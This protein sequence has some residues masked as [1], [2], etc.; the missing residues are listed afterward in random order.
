MSSGTLTYNLLAL[1][2]IS[3]T[4]PNAQLIPGDQFSIV[5]TVGG[6]TLTD[7]T[8]TG[9]MV[10]SGGPI[11]TANINYSTSVLTITTGAFGAT[12]AT[13][14]LAYYPVLP[15]MG[16]FQRQNPG[17]NT[18]QQIT[19][20]QKYAYEYFSNHFQEL[21]STL[22]TE[23]HGSDTDFFWTCSYGENGQNANLFW[24]TNNV[25]GLHSYEFPYC[26]L[27]NQW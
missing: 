9:V 17:V 13:V 2:G 6:N 1:L 5:I 3:A 25:S 15:T 21:P 8:G 7:S 23:W 14:R 20:D 10:I 16:I 26:L 11:L 27:Q 19:F 12:A 24:A 18:Q 4:Q 22:V